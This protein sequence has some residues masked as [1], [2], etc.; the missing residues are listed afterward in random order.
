[1]NFKTLAIMLMLILGSSFAFASIDNVTVSYVPGDS[2]IQGADGTGTLTLE[3]TGVAN[4]SSILITLNENLDLNTDELDVAFSESDVTL[5]AGES[6]D[7]TLT[8]TSDDADADGVYNGVIGVAVNDA[9]HSDDGQTHNLSFNANLD[10]RIETISTASAVAL[11]WVNGAAIATGQ[12][13]TVTSTGNVDQ[14]ITVSLS[15]LVGPTTVSGS[16]IDINNQ[17]FSLSHAEFEDVVI[18]P[19]NLGVLS[20]G[21]YTGTLTIAHGSQTTDVPVTLSVRDGVHSI[22]AVSTLTFDGNIRGTTATKTLTITNNGD[23]TENNLDVDDSL[24]GFS[25]SVSPSTIVS[26]AAGASADVSVSVTLS[27]SVD[28]VSQDIGNITVSNTDVSSTTR[29]VVAPDSKLA[30]TDLDV[31]VGSKTKKNLKDGDRIGQ[32]AEPGDEVTF[33]LEIS[34]LFTDD[35]DIEIQNVEVEITIRDID[36]GDDIDLDSADFD[37]KADKNEDVELSFTVPTLVDEDTYDVEISITGEDEDNVHHS[38]LWTL[39][40]DVEKESHKLILERATLSP[41]TVS[42]SRTSTIDVRVVNIGSDDEE[43][44]KVTAVNSDL[45]LDYEKNFELDEGDNDDSRE[46]LEIR[47]NSEGIAPGVYPIEIDLFRGNNREE[48]ESVE[49]TVRACDDRSNGL[50]DIVSNN[51]R[52]DSNGFDVIG[53]N[54]ISVPNS[55]VSSDASFRNS[56]YYMPTLAAIVLVLGV[57]VLFILPRF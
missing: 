33:K 14:T 44:V 43:N 36:D 22:S 28:T 12:T 48:S 19:E 6:K 56:D 9:T 49:L 52:S 27:D 54:P 2:F 7:I 30:I 24:S 1:M 23:Y 29:V 26:I 17:G 16:S 42:C 21:A 15:N 53:S 57:L 31:K 40:L 45:G 50:D 10:A 39:Q 4:I 51:D 32:E 20:V 13:I 25:A 38:V 11:E 37:I 46:K 41:S 3:N 55:V 8:I 18:T 47:V 34:N 35:E 5:D